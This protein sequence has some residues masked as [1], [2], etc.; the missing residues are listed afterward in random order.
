MSG[1]VESC[2]SL[3][4]RVLIEQKQYQLEFEPSSIYRTE[5]PYIN[6]A[7][8]I[9]LRPFFILISAQGK[10]AQSAEIWAQFVF[11]NGESW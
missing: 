7:G 5:N 10:E 1:E 9:L 3:K 6:L 2:F 11:L 8:K 4:E